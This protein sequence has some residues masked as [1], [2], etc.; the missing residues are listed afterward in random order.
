MRRRSP[1]VL[2][3]E[4]VLS[5][6]CKLHPRLE[7]AHDL[8]MS[9]DESHLTGVSACAPHSSNSMHDMQLFRTSLC[10]RAQ[11]LPVKP[12]HN[13]RGLKCTAVASG[14]LDLQCLGRACSSQL[15]W[16]TTYNTDRAGNAA[17]GRP[18]PANPKEA[19]ARKQLYL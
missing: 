9:R 11:C 12:L 8:Y 17:D 1:A 4:M 15:Y 6:R 10:I 7:A 18:A 5:R 2:L 19:K 13:N 16:F 3:S 14:L